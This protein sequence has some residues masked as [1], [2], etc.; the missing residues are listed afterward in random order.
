METARLRLAAKETGKISDRQFDELRSYCRQAAQI[1]SRHPAGPDAE[2]AER[3]RL[4]KRQEL[5]KRHAQ[6]MRQLSQQGD[7]DNASASPFIIY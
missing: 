1:E 4:A 5:A 6:A 2:A 7:Q 3:Q